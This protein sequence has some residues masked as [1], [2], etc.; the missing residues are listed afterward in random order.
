MERWRTLLGEAGRF[1]AVGGVA[2]LVA[3]TLFNLLVH[4]L[5]DGAVAVMADQ[6]I[7]AYVLANTVG[8]AISYRLS[9]YWAFKDRPPQHSDGGRTMFVLINVVTMSLPVA[10]LWFSRDVLG[11]DSPLADNLAANVIG[12]A[13]GMLAR[14]YLFRRFVFR[15]PI[16][17]VEMYDDPADLPL[18]D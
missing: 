12:L 14:F 15:R 7:P 4:G 9:R 17:L 8:M 18:R 11:H 2:T 5:V 16:A 13:A 3:F 1:L 6:P 10:C